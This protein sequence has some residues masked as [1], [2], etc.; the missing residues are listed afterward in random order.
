[1]ARID[2]DG[3]DG[4]MALVRGL[5]FRETS[6]EEGHDGD[7]H[8]GAG[9]ALADGLDRHGLVVVEKYPGN[10]DGYDRPDPSPLKV[11]ALRERVPGEAGVEFRGRVHKGQGPGRRR[12]RCGGGCGRNRGRLR[13]SRRAFGR[14]GKDGRESQ[15]QCREETR[16]HAPRPPAESRT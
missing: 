6:L 16:F 8:E 11:A 15:G 3:S 14:Q 1:M 13:R 12:G 2:E 4:E 7:R 9:V 5:G 10:P